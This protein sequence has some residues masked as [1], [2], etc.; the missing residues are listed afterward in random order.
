MRRC[1]NCTE[2][3]FF[4]VVSPQLA[5]F[6]FF[7]VS[8]R[9]FKFYLI[10]VGFGLLHAIL[11]LIFKYKPVLKVFLGNPPLIFFNTL[12]SLLL[13]QLLRYL[14]LS[15]QHREFVVPARGGGNDFIENRKPTATDYLILAIYLASWCGLNIFS[16]SL[17]KCQLV[18]TN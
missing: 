16:L 17:L 15:I 3:C 11:F 10:W 1:R 8:L 7:Y 18:P 2:L 6:F 13:F 9:N 5:L 14:S 4:Y 12:I